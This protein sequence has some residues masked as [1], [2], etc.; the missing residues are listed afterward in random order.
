M[1]FL[2]CSSFLKNPKN[3]RNRVKKKKMKSNQFSAKSFVV[4]QSNNPVNGRHETKEFNEYHRIYLDV[5]YICNDEE[6]FEKN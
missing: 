2:I 5:K 6:A 4:S 1:S 3:F